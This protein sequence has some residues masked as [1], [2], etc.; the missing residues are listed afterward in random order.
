MWKFYKCTLFVNITTEKVSKFSKCILFVKNRLADEGVKLHTCL[1]RNC[2]IRRR[3]QI[4]IIKNI[5]R[6]PS[7]EYRAQRFY[8][9]IITEKYF[10][11]NF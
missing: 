11:I 8:S 7:V 6:E 4:G 2:H 5:K 1:P 9:Y 10:N 3:M